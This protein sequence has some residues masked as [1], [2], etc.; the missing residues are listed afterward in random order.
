MPVGAWRSRHCAYERLDEGHC[1]GPCRQANGGPVLASVVGRGGGAGA[2]RP[3]GYGHVDDAS[4]ISRERRRNMLAM[5]SLAVGELVVF[6]V[7][8]PFL[9]VEEVDSVATHPH[10]WRRCCTYFA[11]PRRMPPTVCGQHTAW[12][13]LR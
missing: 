10:L 8:V 9:P 12:Q 5:A 13:A 3:A 1:V 11:K 4:T 6:H 7:C 2:S